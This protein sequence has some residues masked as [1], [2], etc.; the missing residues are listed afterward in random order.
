MVASCRRATCSVG[1]AAPTIISPSTIPA[2]GTVADPAT[3]FSQLLTSIPNGAYPTGTPVDEHFFTALYNALKIGPQP[4]VDFFR[5]GVFFAAITDNGDNESDASVLAAGNHGP[6]WYAAYF[7]EYFP[8]PYLFTWN[9]INPT[10]TVTGT[11]LSDI[12][13]LP[14]AIQL[15]VTSTNGFAFNTGDAAWTTALGSIW[16][17]ATTASTYYPLVGVPSGGATGMT[18]TVNG[19]TISEFGGGA[20]NWSYEATLN[21][22]IFNTDPPGIGAEISVTYPVTCGGGGPGGCDVCD[23][24][25]CY[26]SCLEGSDPWCCGTS[27]VDEQSDANN[28][29]GCG[30][31]CS[32]PTTA[33]VYGSCGCPDSETLCGEPDA[34]IPLSCI[35]SGTYCD[36]GSSMLSDGGCAPSCQSD[37][38]CG[39][40]DGCGGTCNANCPVDGGTMPVRILR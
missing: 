10:A 38:T 36:A 6:N 4:G 39:T 2:G 32:D 11:G 30:N 23:G 17:S 15:M 9:Y 25:S 5:P 26:S 28:C 20:A 19:V 1:G 35:P 31:V 24:G 37:S 13:Q 7:A 12:L 8:K 34:G 18:V 29:G 3:A 21:A 27:C 40:T 33:C 16:A 22:L 14:P